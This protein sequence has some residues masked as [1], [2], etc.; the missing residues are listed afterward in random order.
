MTQQQSLFED[1][2]NTVEVQQTNNMP[3]IKTDRA[4]YLG[5]AKIECMDVYYV[6]NKLRE[7][8][9]MSYEQVEESSTTRQLLISYMNQ[10][11]FPTQSR[12]MVHKSV[13]DGASYTRSGADLLQSLDM[14]QDLIAFDGTRK[15]IKLLSKSIISDIYE[16]NTHPKIGYSWVFVVHWSSIHLG[17]RY[18]NGVLIF[19]A[20]PSDVIMQVGSSDNVAEVVSTN[21]FLHTTIV[22]MLLIAGDSARHQVFASDGLEKVGPYRSSWY[23]CV[24]GLAPIP[25]DYVLT[26]ILCHGIADAVSKCKEML[27]PSLFHE[28]MVVLKCLNYLLEFA[29]NIMPTDYVSKASDWLFDN[30]DLVIKTRLYES[31]ETVFCDALI[32]Y[33]FPMDFLS[34]FCLSK[35]AIKDFIRVYKRQII[36]DK[37][38]KISW[39]G[40]E[41]SVSEKVSVDADHNGKYFKIY[42]K[43]EV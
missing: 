28:K 8:G 15:D 16:R 23:E 22:S 38:I 25:G 14:I 35:D 4:L 10:L 39:K 2:Q 33:G 21:G 32:G 11:L 31:V 17:D 20:T 30:A 29:E 18:V 42:F 7:E 5:E 41:D 12:H 24:F 19:S 40:D 43:Q 34:S 13:N 37:N 1:P 9:Y 36:L 3:T 26:S 27:D 6:G